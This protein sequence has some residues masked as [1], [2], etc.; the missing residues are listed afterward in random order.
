VVN[1][2]DTASGLYRSGLQFAFAAVALVFLEVYMS[3][4]SVFIDF[5]VALL[6][7]DLFIIFVCSFTCLSLFS[8]ALHFISGKRLI[9]K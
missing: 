9:Y 1:F 7:L 6:G 3:F 8:L 4:A 5:L 2:S